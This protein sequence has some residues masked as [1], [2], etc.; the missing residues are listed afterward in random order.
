M[1]HSNS[2]SHTFDQQALLKHLLRSRDTL[3]RKLKLFTK[4]TKNTPLNIQTESRQMVAAT[5]TV[6]LS[7]MV[8]QKDRVIS[9]GDDMRTGAGRASRR[10]WHLTRDPGDCLRLRGVRN[11]RAFQEEEMA[12]F[13]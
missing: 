5:E 4:Y 13:Q 2:L 1:R 7:K 10:K 8:P 9:Q 12:R 3:L 6:T 11:G